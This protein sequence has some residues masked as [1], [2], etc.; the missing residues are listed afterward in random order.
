MKPPPPMIDHARV[1]WWAWS[2]DEPFGFCGDVAV[3]GLAVVRYDSGE[4]YRFSC[5]HHWETVNDSHAHDEETAK[6]STPVNY[7]R[8]GQQIVW[9]KAGK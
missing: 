5:D 7:L 8:S 1:L 2:G 4:V 3:Y 6:R 9:K